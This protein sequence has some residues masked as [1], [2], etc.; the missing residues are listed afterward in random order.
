MKSTTTQYGRLAQ[1]LHWISSILII[2][3]WPL[4]FAMVRIG[5][6]SSQT[7][8][9]Q[10][11]VAIALIVTLIT[12][13][14]V[15]WHFVD[16]TPDPPPELTAL[17]TKIFLWTHNLLYIT[18][19]V[20]ATSGIAM[21]ISSGLGISPRNILPEA[22]ESTL[23]RSAHSVVS[24]IFILLLFAHIGGIIRYQLTKGNTLA[25]MGIPV[26]SAK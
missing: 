18:L 22:I 7:R 4:G 17:N 2:I 13:V 9:Y 6:S 8:L 10:V 23:P 15:I 24:K 26:S 19:F 16:E 20:L 12:I 11:H 14:R 25:R 1:A 3:L 21:L 5:S